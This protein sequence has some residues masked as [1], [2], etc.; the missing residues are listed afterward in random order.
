MSASTFFCSAMAFSTAGWHLLPTDCPAQTSSSDP[1]LN[2]PVYVSGE[3]VLS[4][5][6]TPGESL[7]VAWVSSL[8]TNACTLAAVTAAPRVSSL[9]NSY[10]PS[11]PS[12]RRMVWIASA[13]TAQL[14]LRSARTAASSRRSLLRPLA[15]DSKATSEW[16]KGTD[17]LRVTVE[18][19]RSR[20]S[21]EMGSFM[22]RWSKRAFARPKLPSAFSKSIGFTLCGIA[23]EPISPALVFCLKRPCEIYV[24]MS[25]ARS[26]RIVLIRLQASKRAAILS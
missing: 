21:R 1:N 11:T 18:S 13:V 19:V 8:A 12:R 16:P 9:S 14:L 2:T 25:R 22:E 20:C 3:M 24:Q 15:M 4:S 17:M 10:A 6:N 7:M 5:F 23:D 26:M